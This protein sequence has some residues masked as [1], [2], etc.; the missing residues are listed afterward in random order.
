[1][2]YETVYPLINGNKDKLPIPASFDPQLIQLLGLDIEKVSKNLVKPQS[3]TTF[4]ELVCVG[5]NTRTDTLNAIIHVKKGNGFSG[6][7]CTKGSTEY[8]A[9]WADWNNNGYFEQY[10]GTAQIQVHDLASIPT[11]GIHYSV[12]LPIGKEVI[13]RLKPCHKPQ[14][15]HPYSRR[16]LLGRSAFHYRF[17]SPQ[18]VLLLLPTGPLAE[19]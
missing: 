19:G 8:V 3:K 14:F 16:T 2:A 13:N 10:L 12:Q 15:R 5:L 7:L 9:F 17:Q 6:N 4:E 18:V 1:M 11:E